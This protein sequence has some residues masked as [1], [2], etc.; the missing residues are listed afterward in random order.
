M[1]RPE[2]SPPQIPEVYT[3]N[4]TFESG[5]PEMMAQEEAKRRARAAAGSGGGTA[6]YRFPSSTGYQ[7][8]PFSGQQQVS[9]SSSHTEARQ[10]AEAQLMLRLFDLQ[11]AVPDSPPFS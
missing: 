11:Q 2:E 9:P 4:G 6:G 7:G 3:P 8:P 1:P 5:P 10:Q